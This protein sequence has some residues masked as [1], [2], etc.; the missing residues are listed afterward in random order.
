MVDSL[1][2]VLFSEK[3]GSVGRKRKKKKKKKNFFNLPV[4]SIFTVG[5]T[6]EFVFM[7]LHTNNHLTFYHRNDIPGATGVD[8]L[9]LIV[10]RSFC[11]WGLGKDTEKLLT[12]RSDIIDRRRHD[13]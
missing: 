12:T 9:S 2:L 5:R 6:P 13:F 11:T 8:Y 3:S 10:S 7:S 4:G 1:F